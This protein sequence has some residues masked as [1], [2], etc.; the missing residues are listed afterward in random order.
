MV[1]VGS[2]L[3]TITPGDVERISVASAGQPAQ[4]LEKP[5]GAKGILGADRLAA[6]H[7]SAKPGEPGART[8]APRIRPHAS[9]LRVSAKCD[10]P[11]FPRRARTL[12][13]PPLSKS[14]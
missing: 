7:D 14:A 5:A 3:L 12:A 2:R 11:L 4:I 9:L 1:T 8:L 6:P 13:A 10:R